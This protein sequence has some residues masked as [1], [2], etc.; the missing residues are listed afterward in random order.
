MFGI[1]ADVFKRAT[2]QDDVE[3]YQSMRGDFRPP[4]HWSY[5]TRKR[6]GPKDTPTSEG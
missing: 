1:F 5:E 4:V 2:Y 3:L 6:L